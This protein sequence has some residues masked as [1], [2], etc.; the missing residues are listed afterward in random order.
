MSGILLASIGNSYGSKPV[1]ESSPFIDDTT[2]TVGQT[3]SAYVGS[4]TGTEPIIYSYQWK[5]NGSN[6][7]GATSSSYAVQASDEGDTLSVQVTASNDIGST[8]ATSASTSAVGPNVGQQQFTSPG[9]YSW[10]APAG[11]TSVSVVA[12]GGGG[13]SKYVSPAGGDSFKGGGGGALAYENNISVSSGSSYTIVV[14]DR[15]ISNGSIQS[16]S[17]GNSRFG[18]GFCEAGG[19]KVGNTSPTTRA[20]GGTVIYG[21]NAGSGGN[22]GDGGAVASN[23]VSGGGGGAGGYSGQGGD[24]SNQFNSQLTGQNGGGG[25]GGGGASRFGYEKAGGGGGVGIL[26]QGSSGAGGAPQSGSTLGLQGGGGS[27]GSGGSN[28]RNGGEYGGGSGGWSNTTT[29]TPGRGAVRIIW[30][31]NTRQFPS[32]NTGNL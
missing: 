28:T 23:S 11:V 20:L 9:T 24:G 29:N 16:T 32:T 13:G 5:N 8:S 3:I 17:G 31:G 15:G 14:G 18:S 12:V 1:N 4:W 19:G 6:I 10:V 22:G 21:A 2:P 30:P 25:G 27:G 7:S 26:G